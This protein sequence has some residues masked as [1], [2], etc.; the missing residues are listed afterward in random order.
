MEDIG[1]KRLSK[2]PILSLNKKLKQNSGNKKF[3][4]RVKESMAFKVLKN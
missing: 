2:G 1:Q 4:T 3:I